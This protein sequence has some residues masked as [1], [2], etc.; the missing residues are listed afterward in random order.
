MKNRRVR[1]GM[2]IGVAVLCVVYG[3]MAIEYTLRFFS[4]HAPALWDTTFASVVGDRIVYGEGSVHRDQHDAYENSLGWL[5]VHT[6]GGGLAILLGITQFSQRFR[7]RY[8]HIHRRVGRTQVGI[9][10][11][12][13]IAAIAYLIRTGPEGTFSGPAFYLQLWAL[14]LGTLATSILAVVAIMR[15]QVRVHQALMTANFALLLSASLLRIGYLVFGLAWPDTTHDVINVASAEAVPLVLLLGAFVAIR[16]SD[17]RRISRANEPITVPMWVS[18]TIYVSS[19][20]AL[21]LLVV[22]VRSHIGAVDRLLATHLVTYFIALAVVAAMRHRAQR[23]GDLIGAGECRVIHLGLV[24]APAAFAALWA[25][26]AVPFTVS[27]AF[28]GATLT[29][30]AVTFFAAYGV[31]TWNR[32][33]VTRA[34]TGSAA[35][36]PATQS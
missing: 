18:A 31:V 33:T 5:L 25:I 24:A 4:P 22:A 2:W 3:P 10:L 15:G 7:T 32:R 9:V 19:L 17:T 26:Y 36:Q 14:A 28:Y 8:P 6:I 29:G 30:A 34:G 11:I 1:T 35:R 21:I 27:E 12:S 16:A 23:D 20:L 13:M